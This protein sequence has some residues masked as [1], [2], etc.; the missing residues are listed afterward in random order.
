M[1]PVRR[2]INL[3]CA[4]ALTGVGSYFFFDFLPA[5]A[6]SPSSQDVT[7][8]AYIVGP[9]SQTCKTFTDFH[10]EA[11]VVSKTMFFSYAQGFMT[12]LNMSR[13]VSGLPGHTL[14]VSAQMTRWRIF[15]ITAATTLTRFSSPLSIASMTIYQNSKI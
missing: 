9:G 10:K 11:P 1:R 6:K 5:H 8:T 12:A 3:I 13:S 4:L 15:Y 2:A 14:K 7:N